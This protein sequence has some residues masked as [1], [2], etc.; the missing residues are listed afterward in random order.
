MSPALSRSDRAD[1][2]DR[3]AGFLVLAVGVLALG[4]AVYLRFLRPPMLPED[5]RFTGVRADELPPQFAQWLTIVFHTWGGF[6]AGFGILLVTVGVHLLTPAPRVLRGGV[7][8]A[9]VVAFGGFLA[10]NLELG[11]DFLPGGRGRD[12]PR[13]R[14][15]GA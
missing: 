14:A 9:L 13:A 10:S 3:V 8:L 4:T 15:R 2:L 6:V 7:A 1:R 11:S 5:V 12:R